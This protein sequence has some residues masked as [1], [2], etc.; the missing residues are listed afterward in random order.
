[1]SS[2]TYTPKSKTKTPSQPSR[3]AWSRK[4]Y[5]NIMLDFGLQPEEFDGVH[6][7]KAV[8]RGLH[9]AAQAERREDERRAQKHMKHRGVFFLSFQVPV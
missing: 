6:E 3:Q 5:Q 1:M 9:N 7:G 2:H 8:A 4:S